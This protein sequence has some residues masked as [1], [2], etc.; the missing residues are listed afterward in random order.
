MKMNKLKVMLVDEHTLVRHGL[1][2]ILKKTDEFQVIAEAKDGETAMAMLKQCTPEV[3]IMEVDIPGIGGIETVKR[4]LRLYR[5]IKILIVS[6]IDVEPFPSRLLELGVKGYMSK[7][8]TAEEFC[9]AVRTVAKGERYVSSKIAQRLALQ[10]FNDKGKISPFDNLS[11]RELEIVQMIIQGQKSPDISLKL[12]LSR[13][14]INS[15]RYRFF[16]KLNVKSD[17]EV[18]HLAVKYGLMKMETLQQ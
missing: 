13:K 11:P 17:V 4:I 16:K 2:L 6:T 15:Y 12:F 3:V 5:K 7:D 14:T 9:E 1:A 8:A 10:R 18:T